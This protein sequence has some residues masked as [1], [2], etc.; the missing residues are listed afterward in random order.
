ML[1]LS[2]D[3]C[4]CDTKQKHIVK[5]KRAQTNLHICKCDCMIFHC[6]LLV[7]FILL[8]KLNEYCKDVNRRLY[9]ALAKVEN[10][11]GL[12]KRILILLH[13]A[14]SVIR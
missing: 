12:A 8:I 9:F 10:K 11:T 6:S 7:V 14:Q 2:S 5:T 3:D 4:A 1:Y 13:L